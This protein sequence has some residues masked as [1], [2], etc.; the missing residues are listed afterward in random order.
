[1]IYYRYGDFMLLLII[2]ILICLYIIFIIFKSYK[3]NE[4]NMFWFNFG[5]YSLGWLFKFYY[6]FKVINKVDVPDGPIIVCGNHIH[7]MDQ[8]LPI[9][10]INRP[11]HYLAKIEYFNNKKTRWFFKGTGCI[12]VNREIH[13]QNAKDKAMEVLNKGLAL[14]IFPE[15]TRNRSNKP[16]LP[17]K[18]GAVSMA[19]KSNATIIPFA[20]KGEYKFRSKNLKIIFGKPYKVETDDIPKETA[21]L[22]KIILKLLKEN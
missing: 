8:F 1:M 5:K 6:P 17:F 7:L 20:I 3:E 14:G 13:D 12:P 16:L 11:I 19:I 10:N 9:L 21:K 4:F 18:Y 22:E 15:G 2:L